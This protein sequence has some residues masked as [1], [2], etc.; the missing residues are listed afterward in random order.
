MHMKPLYVKGYLKG[1]PVQRIMVDGGAG[2]N[3]MS[4]S[5]FEKM[6]Y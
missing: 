2:V 3:V 4:L 1:R 5:T 6:G